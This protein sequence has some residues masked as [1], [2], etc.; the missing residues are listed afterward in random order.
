MECAEAT[1][2]SLAEVDWG[3]WPPLSVRIGLDM[4]EAQEREDNY[5]GP[6]VN[7]TARVM[8]AAH[9]GQCNPPG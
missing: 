5:Y 9:G 6:T 7:Q 4:G 2:E 1:Q 8:A 3:T